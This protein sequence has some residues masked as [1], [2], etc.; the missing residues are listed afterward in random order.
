MNDGALIDRMVRVY[1]LRGGES[2]EWINGNED[3]ADG[4]TMDG[5][6]PL[7]VMVRADKEGSSDISFPKGREGSVIGLMNKGEVGMANL[8]ASQKSIVPSG[9]IYIRSGYKIGGKGIGGEGVRVGCRSIRH[10]LDRLLVCQQ[11]SV[12]GDQKF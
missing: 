4:I 7:K 6:P 5:T 9:E 3:D 12:L 2:K 8:E 1:D 11:E 10:T